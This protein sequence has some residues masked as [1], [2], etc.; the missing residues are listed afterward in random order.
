M[1]VPIKNQDK[2]RAQEHYNVTILKNNV[3]IPSNQVSSNVVTCLSIQGLSPSV[4]A[5]TV[6]MSSNAESS[7][8]NMVQW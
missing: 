2:N 1:F 5:R 3:N 4:C 8:T 6:G 7:G